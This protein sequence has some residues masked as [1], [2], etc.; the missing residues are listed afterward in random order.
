MT[1]LMLFKTSAKS[2]NDAMPCLPY[3]CSMGM[4]AVTSCL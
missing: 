2:P 4:G 3:G 1:R